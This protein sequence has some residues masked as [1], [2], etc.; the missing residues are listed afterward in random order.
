MMRTIAVRRH[1]ERS[2]LV[3]RALVEAKRICAQATRVFKSDS[4]VLQP[5]R[6][7]FELRSHI[8]DEPDRAKLDGTVRLVRKL[9]RLLHA[10]LA[11]SSNRATISG[12]G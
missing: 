2:K 7:L 5:A 9:A 6:A 8:E 10:A 11:A 12:G 3:A 4:E 1:L